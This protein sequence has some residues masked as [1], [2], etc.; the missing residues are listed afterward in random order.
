MIGGFFAA[1]F[2]IGTTVHWVS[3]DLK[4]KDRRNNSNAKYYVDKWGNQRLT[5]NG[6][7]ATISDYKDD[8]EVFNHS[9]DIQR[10]NL[11]K[12]KAEVYSRLADTEREHSKIIGY[13]SP[14]GVKYRIMSF[15][16]WVKKGKRT[17]VFHDPDLVIKD[18]YFYRLKQECQDY[19]LGKMSFEEYMKKEMR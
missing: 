17:D 7:K 15:D 19:V 2:G 18:G 11:Y 10:Y 14:A 9:V 3:E 8:E 4:E 12:K 1:L 16:E 6:R 13:R 5:S